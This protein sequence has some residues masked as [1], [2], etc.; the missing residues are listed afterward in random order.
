MRRWLVA[1]AILVGLVGPGEHGSTHK[2][3]YI[4]IGSLVFTGFGDAATVFTTDAGAVLTPPVPGLWPGQIE[5][6][7]TGVMQ[8]PDGTWGCCIGDDAPNFYSFVTYDKDWNF[9]GGWV[10]GYA[11]RG[12]CCDHSGAFYVITFGAAGHTFIRKFNTSGA[13]VQSWDINAAWS[14]TLFPSIAVSLDGTIAYFGQAYAGGA[15]APP[16]TGVK[17]WN[18][19]TDSAMSDL[20]AQEGYGPTNDLGICVLQDGTLVVGWYNGLLKHYSAAGAL[21]NTYTVPDLNATGFYQVT[22]ADDAESFFVSWYATSSSFT[23]VARIRVSDGVLL[24][25]FQKPN[26]T[27]FYDGPFA[28]VRVASGIQPTIPVA[29]PLAAQTPCTPQAL[30][31]NGGK[32]KAGCNVGGVGGGHEYDVTDAANLGDV[33]QHDDP[34]DGET[35]TGAP[36]VTL[37]PWIELVH[38]D[39]PSGDKTTYRRAFEEL[40]DADTYQGGR[41]ESGV[42]AIGDVEHGLG[43]EQGGFEA[44]TAD[45]ELS[46]VRDRLIENLADDQDLDGDECRIK[47]ASD[48]ARAAGT[49]P[50]VLLR[51]IV[52]KGA[53]ESS[54]RSRLT[55]V[56]WLFSDFGPFGPGRKDPNWTFNDLG[57]AA[58]NMTSDTRAQCIPLHYGEKSDER[59][60]DPL[61]N[62]PAAKGLLPGFY[63]GKFDL[64]GLVSTPPAATG[65]TF[66]AFVALITQL[67]ADGVPTVSWVDH[68]GFDIGTSDADRLVNEG[69]PDT[70]DRMAGIIGQ[71][72]LDECLQHGTTTAPAATEWGFLCTGLGPW[73]QYTGVYGSDLGGGDPNKTHDRTKL[74]PTARADILVPGI[75]WPYPDPYLAL[76]NPDTGR[77]FWLTGAFVTGPLLDDHL[78]GVVTLAFNAIGIEEVGDGS[79]LPIMR[80]EDAKQHRLENHWIRQWSSGLYATAV[81]YPQFEDGVPMVRSSSFRAR[82]NFFKQQLGGE[83]LIVSWYTDTQ[84]ANLDIVRQWNRETESRTGVNQHGQVVDFGLDETVD[85]SAWPR[86]QHVT[87][88]FGP[89]VRTSGEERENVVV[90]SCDWDPDFEKL[91]AGP[92]SFSSA[93]GIRKY[94]RRIKQGDA[95]D[96]QILD[97]PSHFQWILQ[98]RLARL[99]FGTTLLEVPG[100]LNPWANYDVGQ[101]VLFTSEDG[102]GPNGYVDHPFIILRRKPSIATGLITF[103]LWDVRDILIDTAFEGGLDRLFYE[104]DDVSLEAVETDDATL[105]PLEVL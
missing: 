52:Q 48:A 42:L 3:F 93:A 57:S 88:V 83:G 50:R 37:E 94:K 7:F 18:L 68:I 32:G 23:N 78:N 91:R 87:D 34:D 39:Y 13:L 72:D 6:S 58:P 64:T 98:R 90:G 81:D 60:K 36:G 70:Y 40:A 26:D 95:I 84:Q 17:R 61:T 63:L 82:Q 66:A 51:G 100:P 102:P 47:V 25:Q 33:P 30:V 85:T 14:F 44:G 65:R 75:N 59:A 53:L 10:N 105:A 29:T 38:T 54:L 8:L 12:M 103:T 77:T 2:M 4:P 21:L 27:F 97:N 9:I 5:T 31:G 73:F 55:V 101:G 92:F 80:V 86:L 20:I 15:G 11:T 76:T 79:G 69:V 45:I 104:T 16:S 24:S 67:I 43:N 41:K 99:E 46:G 35:F 89:I 28:M 62:L 96:S 71:A 22:P 19:S 56:D 49:P 74:D 1:L